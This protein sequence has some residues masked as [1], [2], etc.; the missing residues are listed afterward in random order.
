MY[1]NFR[2]IY[3]FEIQY[4][5]YQKNKQITNKLNYIIKQIKKNTKTGFAKKKVTMN[6]K[7]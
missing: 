4:I 6:R 7:N 5:I 2:Y 3:I 1:D